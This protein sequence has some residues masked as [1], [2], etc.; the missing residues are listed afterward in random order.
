MTIGV[1]LCG[2]RRAAGGPLW[3]AQV[4][5]SAGPAIVCGPKSTGG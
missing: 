1:G 2:P 3:A 5:S 4:E